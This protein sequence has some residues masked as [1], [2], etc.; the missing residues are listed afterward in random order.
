MTCVEVLDGSGPGQRKEFF[1]WTDEGSLAALRYDR[2]KI[3]FLEQRAEGFDVWQDP[4]VPLRFPK[5]FDLRADPFEMA[6]HGGAWERWRVEHAFVLVPAQAYVGQHLAT[7]RE[8]P[9]R[10][11][12][13]SFSL[14]QV[15]EKLQQTNSR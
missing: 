15:L 11:K 6:G 2:W 10:Q 3:L 4:L 8:F 12:A 7:Y 14:D 1:Y 13:G 9:P 5:L